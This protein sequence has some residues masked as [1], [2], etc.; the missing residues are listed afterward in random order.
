MKIV[1][2]HGADSRA[3][4]TRTPNNTS[5]SIWPGCVACRAKRHSSRVARTDGVVKSSDDY[6]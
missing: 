5:T 2:R 6:D 4:A 1:P 3:Q